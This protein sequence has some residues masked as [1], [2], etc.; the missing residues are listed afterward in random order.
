MRDIVNIIKYMKD[1]PLPQ[2]KIPCYLYSK[3]LRIYY[4]FDCAKSAADWLGC[5]YGRFNDAKKKHWPV[6]GYF[7]TTDT[8]TIGS[9]ERNFKEKQV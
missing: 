5:G 1:N 4:K 2:P 7:I 9:I 3:D 6:N 8:T